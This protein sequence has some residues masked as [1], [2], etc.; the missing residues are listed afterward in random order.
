MNQPNKETFSFAIDRQKEIYLEGVNGRRPIVPVHPHDLEAKAKT[1][2]SA[3]AFAYMAGGAGSEATMRTNLDGFERWKIVPRMMRDVS[4]RDTSV[5]LFGQKLPAPFLLAPIGVLD[6]A[7]EQGDLAVARAAA[8]TGVPMIF[9]NQASV[10]MEKCAA[11]MGA[12]PRWFQLYYSKSNE[13]VESLV[14]RA[15]NCGCTAI[16]VTLDTTMLGWRLRDLDL[17]YLPFIEGRGIAQYVSDPVFQS[18]MEQ[19]VFP[20]NTKR[21]ITAD[22]IISVLNLMYHYPGGNFFQNLFSGKPAKA[23]RTFINIYS[24]P[25]LTWSDISF[26]KSITKLP[27]ILKGILHPEDARRA[28]SE[29]ADGIIVSNHGGRQ[30]DGAIAAIEALP[31]VVAA[32]EGRVPVLMDSGIRNGAHIFKALALGAR[33]VLLGRTYTYGLAI[34]GQRGVEAVINNLK[35][36][37]ELTMGLAGC[38]SVEEIRRDNLAT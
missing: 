33:A 16:V 31:G 2:M 22:T 7:H 1:V 10:A 27:V 12:A 30:V 13:L 34:D 35:A 20:G 11:A 5:E 23:V 3:K 26:L 6:L 28:V 21:S 14:L 25:S 19:S 38:K 17:A 18:L 15:E 9:S 29:G 4:V 36:D 32:V 8:T 37:F 24:R